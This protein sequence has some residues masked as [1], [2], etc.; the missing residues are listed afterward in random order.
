MAFIDINAK[1]LREVC[2]DFA[3]DIVLPTD[4]DY[5]DAIKRWSSLAQRDAAV[6]AFVKNEEDV[7]LLNRYISKHKIPF[8]VKGECIQYIL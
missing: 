6:V 1:Q 5:A 3:G 2:D 7:V 4:A 8:S